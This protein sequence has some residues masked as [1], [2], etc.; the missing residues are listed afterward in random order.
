MTQGAQTECSVTTWRGG[1]RGGGR[2]V[3]VETLL[4]MSDLF[5]SK[6]EMFLG[7]KCIEWSCGKNNG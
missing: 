3:Q 1:M 4:L 6:L 5:D 2:E 7:S